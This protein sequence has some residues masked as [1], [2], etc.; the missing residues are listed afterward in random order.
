[1]ASV[2]CIC[3]DNVLFLEIII[4]PMRNANI[5]VFCVKQIVMNQCPILC[6]AILNDDT[7]KKP[8]AYYSS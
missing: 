6:S 5:H 4:A 2:Q 3:I 8:C 7:I 1:M